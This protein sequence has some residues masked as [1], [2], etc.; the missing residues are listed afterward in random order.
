[1][2]NLSTPDS[3]ISNKDRTL[4]AIELGQSVVSYVEHG[5]A[6]SFL[7]GIPLS[8]EYN[9]KPLLGSEVYF[10]VNR[11]EKDRTNAHLILLAKNENG[12]KAINRVISEANVS[13]FYYKPRCDMELILSLP[14]NDV[15][16]TSACIGGVWKYENHDEI[17]LKLFEHFGRNNFFLEVQSHH[18]DKQRELN[19]HILDLSNKHNIMI[20]GGLDSHM[21]YPEQARQ[22]DD[23]LLSSGIEY[24]DEENWFLDFCSYD[25]FYQRFLDQGVLNKHQIEEALENTNIFQ[26]VE[27]YNSIIFD[28][29]I[30]KLP[31]LYPDKSQ[32]EKDLIL[33]NIIW[34]QW[35]QERL[36]IPSNQHKH[37]EEE[38]QKEFDVIVKTKTSDYF[39]I[40]HEV[41]KKGKEMGGS[42]TLTGSGFSTSPSI[43]PNCL[44]LQ[45]SIE[46]LLVLSCFQSDLYRQNDSLKQNRYP[47]LI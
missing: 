41:V 8:Q 10:V 12:R 3:T 33:K 20:I 16:A 4:R 43:R 7:E 28:K 26:N 46:F 6:I 40:D 23:Y 21:L 45:P 31:T 15:W 2:S 19:K 39:I 22:R 47:I 5:S 1:M 35:E 42:I 18:V 34:K 24:P 36:N 14:K 17:I 30:I 29:N 32:E 44:D 13:G 9:I 27:P 11:F 37:Y 38:I 25:T